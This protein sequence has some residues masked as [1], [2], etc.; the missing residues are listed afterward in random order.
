MNTIP[1]KAINLRVRPVQSVDLCFPVDGILAGVWRQAAAGPRDAPGAIPN[2]NLLGKTVT[3]FDLANLYALLGTVVTPARGKFVGPGKPVVWEPLPDSLQPLGWGRLM[4]DSKTIRQAMSGSILFELRAEQVK[5]ALDKAVG[6]RENIW[7]QKYENSVYEATKLAYDRTDPNSKLNRLKQLAAISQLTRDRVEAECS[8]DPGFVNPSAKDYRPAIVNSS[9]TKTETSSLKALS[10]PSTT[11][12]TKMEQ[13]WDVKRDDDGQPFYDYR[14]KTNGKQRYD[15]TLNQKNVV[16]TNGYE[17]RIPSYEND[18][19]FQRAQVSLLDEQLSAVSN[20]NYAC[21]SQAE[22]GAMELHPVGLTPRYLRNDL[23]AIDLDIKRLQ[24]AYMDTML[25]SPIDGVVT[26]VFR[27]IGDSVRAAQPVV[28]IEN[29]ALIYLVGTLKCRGSLQI[30]Q[31]ISVTT[32]LADG[33]SQTVP[34]KVKAV[35]GHDSENDLWDLLILCD[36][37]LGGDKAL[38]PINYNLDFDTTTID[39]T[40]M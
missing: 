27:N 21:G 20:T 28:R 1:A 15:Y 35:R 38:L 12:K 37:R 17:Y 13:D 7:V 29:D 36:N 40:V 18:A 22:R 25:V 23:A 31:S 14:D 26:G 33:S 2:D 39:V 32:T 24:V 6:Q 11:D 4:Y 10:Y 16:T 9:V 8:V 3:A 19:K 30:G 5:A 34:G